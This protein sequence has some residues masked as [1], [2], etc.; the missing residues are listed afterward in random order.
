MAPRPVT[1]IR[2]RE[3]SG[4]I[5]VWDKGPGIHGPDRAFVFQRFYRSATTTTAGTGLGLAIVRHTAESHGGVVWIR[6]APDGGA[7]V[8]FSLT[9][10]DESHGLA[11]PAGHPTRP[12]SVS[13]AP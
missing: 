7:I 13:H 4:R 12:T 10:T 6:D 2:I 1:T 3:R 8:G 5:E 11:T 9:P